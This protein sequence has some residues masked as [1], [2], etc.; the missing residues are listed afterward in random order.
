MSDPQYFE[1]E[2]PA[3]YF[4]QWEE[5]TPSRGWL[6]VK[7][8]S[9]DGKRFRLS[10]YDAVTL[11]Q[12]LDICSARGAIHY[13]EPNLIVVTEVNTANVRRAVT[14]LAADGYFDTIKAESS[15]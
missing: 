8:T 7:V 5:D 2:F 10:F 4:G 13:A 9:L 3:G 11:K 14:D 15:E 6:E 12:T 1:V